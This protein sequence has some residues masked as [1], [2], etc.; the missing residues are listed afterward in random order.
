LS[1]R[2]PRDQGPILVRGLVDYV[3]G[4]FVINPST[5]PEIV[6][7]TS[8]GQN[9]VDGS[10][11]EDLGN[12]VKGETAPSTTFTVRNT[13]DATLTISG[14]S[15]PPGFSVAEELL[16]SLGPGASDTFTV[17]LDSDVVG[18]KS[19]QI[20]IEN[21]EADENPFNFIIEGEVTSPP[22]T[23]RYGWA[24]RIGGTSVDMAYGLT[25][26]GSGNLYVTG[27]FQGSTDFDP[28]PGEAVRTSNDN[29]RDI[30][31]AKYTSN[32]ALVWVKTYGGTATDY[33]LDIAV[34]GSS[35]IYV[36][37]YFDDTVSFGG[38]SRTSNGNHDIFVLKLNS[39]GNTV[40]VFSAEGNGSDSGRGIAVDGSGNVYVAGQ[41]EE[42]VDFGGHER[43]AAGYWDAY[44][45]KLS[46]SGNTSWVRHMGG[47]SNEVVWDVAVDASD[48]AYT[49]GKFKS[50]T[51]F[52]RDGS[53]VNRTSQGGDD[54]FVAKH[55]PLGSLAWVHGIGG[56][57]S[58]Q[59]W[60]IAVD[61]NRNVYATG[62]FQHTVDFNPQSGVAN[63]ESDG[64]LDTFVLRL[65]SNGVFGWVHQI[66]GASGSTG[67]D[68][69]ADSDQGV[70]VTGYF[71]GTADFDT[72]QSGH[73]RT[74]AGQ[75][76][77]FVAK[78]ESSG[79]F[80]WAQSMGGGGSDQGQ[81]ITVDSSGNVY[82]TGSFNGTA[83]FDPGNGTAELTSA[84]GSDVFL[85]QL[86]VPPAQAEIWWPNPYGVA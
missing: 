23:G 73:E 9:I 42:T 27:T 70:Y 47:P 65:D 75:A 56:I 68:I 66:G 26:D 86:V 30:F 3:N 12:V 8:G 40:W 41:F 1:L 45:L 79:G 58:E 84:G 24:E 64:G 44:L 18:P 39:L 25:S 28:G 55:T 32:G 22:E 74:S 7:E 50:T 52:N 15:L 31:V 53:P 59:G 83:D 57:S 72:T 35:N 13:G 67:L 48:N 81:G 78:L 36:T 51:D 63:V 46:N 17:Q 60:A 43:S 77:I 19:G 76:D 37:G 80:G 71:D 16:T 33:G 14:M 6:V 61:Q 4:D 49:T 34:D 2:Q 62:S 29:S 5:A 69:H 82:T 85:S 54:I 20:R 38:H 10:H 11:F 21:N